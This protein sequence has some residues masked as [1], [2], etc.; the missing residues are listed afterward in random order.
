MYSLYTRMTS[1]VYAPIPSAYPDQGPKLRP[2]DP[3]L[4]ARMRLAVDV[5]DNKR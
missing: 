1:N 2:E 4:R 5:S 3:Y